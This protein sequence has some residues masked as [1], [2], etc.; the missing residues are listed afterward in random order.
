[1]TVFQPQDF[2][3]MVNLALADDKNIVGGAQRLIYAADLKAPRSPGAV[4]P[5]VLVVTI[6]GDHGA[7]YFRHDQRAWVTHNDGH[8]VDGIPKLVY[9]DQA[10]STFPLDA[11]ISLSQLREIVNEYVRDGHRPGG[12]TWVPAEEYL[13]W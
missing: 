3:R 1:M 12:V 9:D 2:D 10:P 6:A 13:P 5:S 4:A 11:V 7:G 8:T